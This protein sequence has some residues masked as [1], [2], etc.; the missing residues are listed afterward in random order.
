MLPPQP[1]SHDKVIGNSYAIR[2]HPPD[3]ST[4][5]IMDD[6]DSLKYQ[7]QVDVDLDSKRRQSERKLLLKTVSDSIDGIV[8]DLIA[9][10][11][12]LPNPFA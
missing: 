9:P 3:A 5:I 11:R 4:E 10:L 1:P 8:T 7:A 2:L 12:A 6:L